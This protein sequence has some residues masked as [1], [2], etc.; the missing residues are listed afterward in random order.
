MTL[1]R[2]ILAIIFCMHSQWIS[3]H[4]LDPGYLELNEVKPNVFSVLF[5]TPTSSGKEITLTPVFPSECNEVSPILR[6]SIQAGVIKNWTVQCSGD[7]SGN[8]ITIRGLE[9]TQTDVLVRISRLSDITQTARLTS[10]KT[11]FKV[12]DRPSKT[13]VISMY[14][15]LGIE[16]ILSG[17][18]HL[19][20][21]L[22]LLLIVQGWRPLIGTITAFTVAHSI[23]LAA[24]SLGYIHVAQAP[25]EAVIA[26]SI[27]FLAREI[28]HS[29]QGRKSIAIHRPWLVAFIFGLLHGFGF[30]GALTE[31]GLPASDVPLA[32]LFFN[33]GVEVGQ[34]LF[35]GAIVVLFFLNRYIQL[36]Q[37]RWGKPVLTYAIGGIAGFWVL[38]R[39]LSFAV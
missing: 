5:K 35:V 20:F 13:E 33:V 15:V 34:L 18:D 4:Q 30:A 17:I 19:L 29:L 21:V 11:T 39:I 1:K 31:I 25:V 9:L 27:V 22:A 24:A 37:I 12:V 38:E 28:I 2:L 32:L 16:H 10:Q 6:R 7:I 14:L 3:A 8:E 26:L 36:P 23:T